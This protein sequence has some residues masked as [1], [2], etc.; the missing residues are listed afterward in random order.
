MPQ[1]STSIGSFG[2]VTKNR[3]NPMCCAHRHLGNIDC[4]MVHTA[5]LVCLISTVNGHSNKKRKKAKKCGPSSGHITNLKQSNFS[6]DIYGC[7]SEGAKV[8]TLSMQKSLNAQ[9]FYYKKR[10]FP[11]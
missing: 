4:L 5:C 8:I 6:L 2:I 10:L 9:W 11:G 1:T 7:A 3:N